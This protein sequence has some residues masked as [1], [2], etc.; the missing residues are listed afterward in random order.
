M[1]KLGGSYLLLFLNGSLM[2]PYCFKALCPHGFWMRTHGLPT[3]AGQLVLPHVGVT[4]ELTFAALVH[5]SCSK[6]WY[7]ICLSLHIFKIMYSI[8]RH[9]LIEQPKVVFCSYCLTQYQNKLLFPNH[10]IL[11]LKQYGYNL[12]TI[13]SLGELLRLS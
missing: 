13:Y 2:Q 1:Q 6:K 4:R 7:A 12:K 5:S 10:H 3:R 11:M 9:L 8:A